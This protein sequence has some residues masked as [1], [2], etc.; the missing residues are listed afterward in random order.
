MNL[1]KDL[2]R[3]VAPILL[4]TLLT[5]LLG[6]VDTFMLSQHSDEAV[7]A[8]GMDNQILSLIFL[9]FQIINTGTSVL[10]AQ[11]FGAQL[12]ER[13]VKVSGVALL[14]NVSVGVL[15]SLLLYA[16]AG[17]ILTFMGLRPE[18][19]IYGCPYMQIVGGFAFAQAVSST[20]SAILRSADLAVYPMRVIAVVNVVN[21]FGNYTLIFGKFGMPA[22]GV[23]GAAIST[24]LSRLV[25]MVMLLVMLRRHLIASIPLRL[26]RPFPRLELKKL[27][28]IGLPSAG[29][30]ISYNLQQLTLL[31]FVN[32][33]GNDA[34]AARTYVLN[35]VM[36]VFLY[37]ICIAQ[38][39][40]IVVGHLIGIG[41]TRAA[42]LVGRFACI[43]SAQV[44][45]CFSVAVALCGR[46]IAQM[47]TTNPVIIELIC[48]VFWVDV[49][50]E[51]GKSTNIWATNTLR[52]TGDI[53]Y[54][55]YLGII[56]QW[57]VGVLFGWFFGIGMGFG[58]VGMWFAFVLDENIRGVAFV[59]RWNSFKWANRSFVG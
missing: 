26:F 40:S 43:R 52:A 29:E 33:M 9:L 16:F 54:P 14:L 50:L 45:I 6:V 55:F 59:R 31:Y 11:Y 48:S 1:R 27:L 2:N 57:T 12:R 3:L 39:S 37:A 30:N 35:V 15:V 42:Y 22:L 32:L 56:V 18:L 5:F 17:G 53:F 19:M 38:G 20:V 28:R 10:C 8:V 44:S 4:E 51:L 36:F 21:I 47:L 49:L 41:K 7:A 24:S 25:S 23:E 34:L 46:F 58:L 13:F